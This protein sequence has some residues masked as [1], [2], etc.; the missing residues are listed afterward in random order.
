[1]GYDNFEKWSKIWMTNAGKGIFNPNDLDKGITTD[2]KKVAQRVFYFLSPIFTDYIDIVICKPSASGVV[3]EVREAMCINR[4]M[5]KNDLNNV[6]NDVSIHIQELLK[7]TFYLGVFTHLYLMYFPTREQSYN[8]NLILLKEKWQIDAITADYEMGYYG[9]PNNP[10]LM[11]LWE[12][13]YETNL[14]PT[15]EKNLTPSAFQM[16]KFKAYF[17]NLYISG[18]LL[19]MYYD[20]ST[21]GSLDY[22]LDE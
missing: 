3:P 19:V 10:V 14:V 15:L 1:M 5:N 22:N 20:L 4:L 9:D 18:A 13:Y 12:S 8:V 16:G 2:K 11:D 7:E 17:R 21:K 6:Q